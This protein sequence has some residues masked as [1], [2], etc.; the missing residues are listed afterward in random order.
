MPKPP[1]PIASEKI[2]ITST[3]HMRLYL[4]DLVKSGLYGKNA[5]EAA[6]RL[7]ARAIETMIASGTLRRLP[8]HR[9]H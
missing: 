7:L 1:N 9:G 8:A 3:P 6:E 2:T 5:P 4:E